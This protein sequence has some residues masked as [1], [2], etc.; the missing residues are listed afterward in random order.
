MF[1]RQI[2][3]SKSYAERL[4]GSTPSRGTKKTTFMEVLIAEVIGLGDSVHNT[5][6]LECRERVVN[7]SR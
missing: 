7:G 5:G 3:H 1:L 4:E 2:D 6:V